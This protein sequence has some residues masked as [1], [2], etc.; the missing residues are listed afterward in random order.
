M[1]VEELDL[2]PVEV[3]VDSAV[4]EPEAEPE[5][6][7]ADDSVV[8]VVAELPLLPVVLAV[9]PEAVVVAPY[10]DSKEE[11]RLAWADVALAWRLE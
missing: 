6:P 11:R 10:A 5:E 1:L 4:A 8:V 9:D 7:E 2:V 3:A